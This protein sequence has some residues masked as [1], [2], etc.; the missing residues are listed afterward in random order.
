MKNLWNP[1]YDLNM[2]PIVLN[3]IEPVQKSG[4]IKQVPKRHISYFKVSRPVTYKWPLQPPWHATCNKRHSDNKRHGFDRNRNTTLGN[5]IT[6]AQTLFGVNKS[7]VYVYKITHVLCRKISHHIYIYIYIHTNNC[8]NIYVQL[9]TT[10]AKPPTC[11]GLFRPSSGKHSKKKDTLVV[12][13]N[14]DMQ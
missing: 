8:T 12:S 5:K 14:I 2:Q 1:D 7:L 10:C 3:R 4:S 6:F 13:Y 9:Y 11:F